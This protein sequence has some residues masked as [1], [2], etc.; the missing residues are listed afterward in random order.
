MPGGTGI[1]GLCMRQQRAIVLDDADSDPRHCGDIDRLTGYVTHG[2]AC[3]PVGVEDRVFG[4]IE[5]INLPDNAEFSRRGMAELTAIA[6]AL[7]ER[8]ERHRL[9][10]E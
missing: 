10:K 1:A 4:A 5:M 6:Q 3:V 8:L 9:E 7:G 2:L